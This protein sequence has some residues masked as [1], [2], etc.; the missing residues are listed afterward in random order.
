L[1]RKPRKK[2]LPVRKV[3]PTKATGRTR[4]SGIREHRDELEELRAHARELEQKLAARETELAEALE[5][6]TA[7]SDVLQVISRSPGDLGPIFQA[8]L[9]NATRLCEA[10]FGNLFLCEGDAFRLV[11]MH[12]APPAN[13]EARKHDPLVRPPPDSALA[14]LASTKQVA[15]IA[16][17]KATR[18]VSAPI[19]GGLHHKYG[20]I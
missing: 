7:T 17:I 6:Q 5:R 16:D 1:S 4:V 3:R 14:L 8:M 2:P 15:H 20:R 11:A 10:K 13:A 18:L 19:L 9:E 12:G